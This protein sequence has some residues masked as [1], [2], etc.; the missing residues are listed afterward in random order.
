[1][2]RLAD[3]WVSLAEEAERIDDQKFRHATTKKIMAQL[4]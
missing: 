4:R 1:L 2:E 3:D